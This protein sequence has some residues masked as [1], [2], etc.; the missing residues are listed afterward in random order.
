VADAARSVKRSLN[1]KI[2]HYEGVADRALLDGFWALYERS[3][4]VRPPELTRE[5][6]SRAEFVAVVAQRSTQTWVVW[7]DG[8]PLGLL[9]VETKLE[10]SPWINTDYLARQ[11]PEQTAARR[12]AYVTALAVDPEADGFVARRC[13]AAGVAH[14]AAEEMVLVFDVTDH[15]QTDDL[16]G[17]MAGAAQALVKRH[18]ADVALL[19]I[20]RYYAADFSRR[21]A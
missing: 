4:A 6:L 2:V 16:A 14:F 17:G 1:V 9:V 15:L 18:D 12:V 11:F 21:P 13:M 5:A 8:N 20:T 7:H 10:R 3:Y 19:G